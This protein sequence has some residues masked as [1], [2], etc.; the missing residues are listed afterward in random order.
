MKVLR[1]FARWPWRRHDASLAEEIEYHRAMIQADLEAQGTPPAEAAAASR[2]AMGN[3]T[4]AREEAREVWI[5]QCADRLWRDARHGLRGLRREPTFTATTVLT[6]ALG[7]ATTTAVFSVADAELWRPLPFPRPEELVAITSRGPNARGIVDPVSLSE[8]QEWRSAPALT[9]LAATGWVATHVLRRETAASALVMD[10]T[11]NYFV[12]LSRTLV[13]GRT[14]APAAGGPR[15]AVLTDRAWRRIFDGDSAVVGRQILLDDDPVVITGIVPADDTLGPDPDMFLAIDDSGSAA[16]G[17]AQSPLYSATGRLRPGASADVAR[18]QLQ[19]VRTRRAEVSGD[20]VVHTVVVEDLTAYYRSSNWRPLWFFLAASLVVLLLSAVNVATLLLARA[21]RR[22]REFALRGALGGGTG[23]LARQLVVEGALLAAPSGALGLLLT[24]WIVGAATTVLPESFLQRGA[25]IPVD[26]RA[27][28]FALAVTAVTTLIFALAPIIFLARRIDLSSVLG[29]GVRAGR[30]IA[31]GRA[32][33]VLLTAQIALTMVLLAGAGIF[34]KSFAA[35]AHAPLGFDP[36]NAVALRAS[37]SGP[38]YASDAAMRAYADQLLDG[39][40]AVPGVRTAAI[41]S[42]SPLGSGPLVY[43]VVRDAPR[44]S[45]GSE[46]RA[47]L[48]AVGVGYFGTLGI[49]VSRGRGFTADDVAAAPRVAIVNESLVRQVFG[50]DDPIGRTLD[51]VSRA[52][53]SWASRAQTAVIVGVASNVKEVGLNEVDFGD[54]Y[55]PFAQV[56]SPWIELVVRAGVPPATLGDA[57]RERAAHV[58]PAIPVTSVATF[59]ARVARAL[60]G[61][62][63]NLLLIGAFAGLAVLLASIG[64]Y[65]AVAYSV[66]A[67]TRELGV[68][69]ALGARPG[70]LVGAALWQAGRLGVVGGAIGLAATLLLAVPLGNALYLVPG[71]HEG[72]LYHV[73]TTDPVMLAAAFALVIVVAILAGAVPARRVARVNPVVALRAE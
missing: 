8:L 47:I 54:I 32:R 44:P 40:R 36:G 16:A 7:I 45:A 14:F 66:Q 15:E 51:F 59:D 57:L 39:V 37:L 41:A 9:D 68:R 21:S 60:Q 29:Q 72:L 43:F 4:L 69:L 22:V 61:D 52:S 56:P 12:V 31:E 63:F 42:S 24:A 50:G 3:L 38:R 65:G 5:V 17:A 48:R 6:L 53:A 58:D 27:G 11:P 2:R 28:T 19:A 73:S 25:L 62:R 30:S 13:A 1:R 35:L 46:P 71:Q 23:A 67:R 70:R 49:R 20:A 18:A 34:V 64:I 33:L 10:V 55:L 26:L